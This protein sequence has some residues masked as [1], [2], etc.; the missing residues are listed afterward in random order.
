[1]LP[2][3]VCWYLSY[4]CHHFFFFLRINWQQMHWIT[5]MKH[6]VGVP[7]KF[8]FQVLFFFCW[9][10]EGYKNVFLT[11]CHPLDSYYFVLRNLFFSR[12]SRH[13]YSTCTDLSRR[14]E[15]VRLSTASRK[16]PGN[17]GFIPTNSREPSLALKPAPGHTIGSIPVTKEQANLWCVFSVYLI[18]KIKEDFQLAK[19]S[20]ASRKTL[21]PGFEKVNNRMKAV[22]S[23]SRAKLVFLENFGNILRWSVLQKSA[24]AFI[25]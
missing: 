23:R 22:T 7:L 18:R 5:K 10:C 17:I 24:Q 2:L 4:L 25:Y 16:L 14:N 9:V 19:Q 3:S 8:N 21:P 13:A 1:M 20:K 15:T 6:T 12:C 11:S